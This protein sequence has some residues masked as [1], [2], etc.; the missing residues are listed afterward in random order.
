MKL[1]TVSFDAQYGFNKRKSKEEKSNA[2]HVLGS[3]MQS[4]FE[5]P[6]FVDFQRAFVNLEREFIDSKVD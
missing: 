1:Q 5:V 6:T 4:T 3:Q 2:R